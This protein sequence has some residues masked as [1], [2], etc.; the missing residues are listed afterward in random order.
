MVIL[1]AFG[2][3]TIFLFVAVYRSI[4]KVLS[5]IFKDSEPTNIRRSLILEKGLLSSP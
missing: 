5:L 1:I 2:L 4:M 3:S